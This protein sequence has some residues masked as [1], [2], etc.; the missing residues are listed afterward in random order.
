MFLIYVL[1]CSPKKN[2]KR[3][4]ITPDDIDSL[5]TKTT[6]IEDSEEEEEVGGADVDDEYEYENDENEDKSDVEVVGLEVK[7][8]ASQSFTVSSFSPSEMA[9]E[10]IPK[11]LSDADKA[12]KQSKKIKRKKK[13]LTDDW[14]FWLALV[15]GVG[16]LS[17]A[18]SVYSQTGFNMGSLPGPQELI[19]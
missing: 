2:R 4:V 13:G 8:P 15:G 6:T 16:F 11:W 7:Q 9:N 1:L 17:A 14:R 5:F 10:E 18:W 19:I 12:A 3:R